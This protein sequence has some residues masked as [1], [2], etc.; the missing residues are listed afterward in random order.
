MPATH[1]GKLFPMSRLIRSLS[2]AALVLPLTVGAAAAAGHETTDHTIVVGGT[3]KVSAAPDVAVLM[4]GVE[5]L[6]PALA[7]ATADAAKRMSAVVARLK[8]LGVADAD[9][10]TLVYSVD[11]R[12]APIDP[13]RRDPPRVVG[14]Q[15]SN[16]AQVTIRKIAEA[17]PTLDAA[18]A[19]GAN[20]VR[21]I[22]FTL[23][24]PSA[25]QAEARKRAVA[26][27]LAKA[28]QLAAAGGVTLGPV[29]TIRESAAS[30]PVPVRAMAM[31]SPIEAG[32]LDVVVNVEIRQAIQR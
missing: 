2:V 11:P 13:S 3:G 1:C 30:P 7:D 15:V 9:I 28:R 4:L 18:V 26:D 8:E 16:I 12:T 27:A 24:D 23:A 14:Y 5:S 6:A 19:A 22:R 25:V 17:G 32:Q 31:S 20:A 10:S 21:G 29:L